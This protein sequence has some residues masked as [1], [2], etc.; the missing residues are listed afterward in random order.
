[1]KSTALKDFFTEFDPKALP[2]DTIK[3]LLDKDLYSII[4][5]P[6][7][8]YS[9]KQLLLEMNYY[10]I[11]GQEHKFI[12]KYANQYGNCL[13]NLI[14]PWINQTGEIHNLV[15]I[16]HPNDA[17]RLAKRHLKKMPNYDH[18]IMDSLLSTT[19]VDHWRCQ[20][21]HFI[22]AFLP[23]PTLESIMPI[24]EARCQTLAN[25]LMRRQLKNT[26]IDISDFFLQETQ[27]QLQLSLFGSDSEFEQQTN[28]LLRNCFSGYEKP[29]TTRK[30]CLDMREK[31]LSG[32]FTGPLSKRLADSPQETETE[33]Y[34]NIMLFFF[35]GHDT[36][37]HTLTWLFYELSR[38]PLIQHKLQFE[39]D[40]FF[41]VQYN[42]PIEYDD[43][44]RLP[45]MKRCIAET[46]RLWPAI[47]N[48][49]FR[50]L[51]QDDWITIGNDKNSSQT[52]WLPK[53][54]YVQIPTIFRHRSK[55]LWGDDAECFNP[56]R[57][58]TE[59][60]I[61]GDENISGR[62]MESERYSPFSFNRRNCIGKT[63]SH[64]E[65]RLMILYLLRDFHFVLSPLQ[66]IHNSSDLSII[67]FNKGTLG[68]KNQD[69]QIPV[70]KLLVNLIKRQSCL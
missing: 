44:Q 24:T 67:E 55:E 46:L 1:M 30:I 41:R 11:K 70:H 3:N 50:E 26:D 4:P 10:F 37:G 48:G 49:T 38:N 17:K 39:V 19:N 68:P 28:R 2:F 47:A 8:D 20:R 59:E 14:L 35:A 63:F 25:E 9:I 61:W 65:M 23:K 18:I 32:K 12:E 60:E 42:R 64:I 40:E 29:G 6:L 56:D 53:G 27:A 62:S 58:F 66:T 51:Q 33:L 45:Y 54:T 69:N 5:G 43:L 36:T 31:I 13:T 21:E 57:N 15:V 34:A 52:V 7:Q 22:E 16:L